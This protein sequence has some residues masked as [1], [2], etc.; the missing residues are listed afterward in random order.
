MCSTHCVQYRVKTVDG[1][2]VGTNW[3][4][5]ALPVQQDSNALI[6]VNLTCGSLCSILTL[7]LGQI[8]VWRCKKQQD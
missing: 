7:G 6:T 8:I 2:L 1:A 4:E 3:S 5:F